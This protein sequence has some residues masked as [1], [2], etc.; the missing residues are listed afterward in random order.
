MSCITRP[1]TWHW[2]YRQR[3]RDGQTHTWTRNLHTR[4]LS[5]TADVLFGSTWYGHPTVGKSMPM[6]LQ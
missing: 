5:L 3:Y 6:A 4:Y 2:R 1:P